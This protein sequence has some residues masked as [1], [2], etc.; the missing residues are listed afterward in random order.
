VSSDAGEC[1]M[2]TA[3]LTSPVGVIRLWS[4][5]E[6]ITRLD[7]LDEPPGE[8][9]GE[10]SGGLDESL[11]GPG[12]SCPVLAWARRELEA[13]FAGACGRFTVPVA[14]EGTPFAR[15]V[16]EE[17]RAIPHGTTISY[18][19]L[20]ERVG[21][22]GGARAVGAANGRNPV[23]I[24]VPCHRVI[25]ADGSATGYSGGVWRKRVLLE[26]EGVGTGAWGG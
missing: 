1:G 3:M 11:R 13:Y 8:S 6:A 17:L 7:L 10:S 21:V 5:G 20:A 14:G 12:T 18:G 25:G 19:A 24:L 22:R 16:W 9:P 23:P 26:L 2:S 15:R 4:N